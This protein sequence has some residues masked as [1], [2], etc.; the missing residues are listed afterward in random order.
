L[1]AGFNAAGVEDAVQVRQNGITVERIR[2]M[3]RQGFKNLTLEQIVKLSRG[4][5]I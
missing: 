3:K 4:G 2:S 5:V 1:E